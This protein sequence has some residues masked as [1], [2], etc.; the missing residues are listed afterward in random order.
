MSKLTATVKHLLIINVLIFAASWLN[1]GDINQFLNY[2]PLYDPLSKLFMP[3]QFITYMFVH[4]SETHILF[5]MLS[6]FFIGPTTELLLGRN[7]FLMLYFTAGVLGAV[8][9]IIGSYTISYI[10]TGYLFTPALVGASAAI[11]GLFGALARLLPD[12]KVVVFPIFIPIKLKW[13]FFAY[14]LF[15]L[16][17]PFIGVMEGLGHFAHLGGLLTGY[18]MVGFWKR[19]Y[20]RD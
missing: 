17:A 19:K 9:Q 5:N 20:Q 16:V 4:G 15:S 7:K 3:F 13:A 1:P 11:S 14:G 18:L 6:L 2:L 12:N 10:A 8:L